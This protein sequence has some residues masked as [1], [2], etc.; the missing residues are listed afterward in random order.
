M[1]G[2][3]QEFD[4]L[5][6]KCVRISDSTRFYFL[7]D[8]KLK[9]MPETSSITSTMFARIFLPEILPA[10]IKRVLYLDIDMTVVSS[11]RELFEMD[12]EESYFACCVGY[13]YSTYHFNRIG[14]PFEKWKNASYFNSGMILF[15]LDKWRDYSLTEKVLTFLRENRSNEF[16]FPDQDVLN[17][18]FYNK[19]AMADARYNLCDDF[20]NDYKKT[21]IRREYWEMIDAAI[22]NPAIVHFNGRLKPW[23]SDCI[24]PYAGLWRYYA[25]RSNVSVAYKRGR[26]VKEAMLHSLKKG[27]SLFGLC[28]SPDN[29]YTEY[30]INSARALEKRLTKSSP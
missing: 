28:K 19:V 7:Q 25:R 18:L 14:L 26:S 24:N 12:M 10:D 1:W 15:A 22:V 21:D 8:S 4:E 3:E 9:D 20:C 11:L 29:V 6:K 16:L 17:Y 27:F 5:K 2:G 13:D 23:H 30:S